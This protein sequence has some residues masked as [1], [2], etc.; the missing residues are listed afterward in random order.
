MRVLVYVSEAALQNWRLAERDG[1]LDH[2]HLHTTFATQLHLV[3]KPGDHEKAAAARRQEVGHSAGIERGDVEAA[4]PILD[5]YFELV[6]AEAQAD[7]NLL[8]RTAV[9]N[10]VSAS[11]LNGRHNV[12]DRL[13]IATVESQIVTNAVAR[14][15][16]TGSPRSEREAQT[17]RGPT[18]RLRQGRPSRSPPQ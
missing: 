10:D 18:A 17:C 7:L 5:Q 9:T 2:A 1:A 14:T 12:V 16:Q 11:L 3:A 8:L 4:A 15:E 6:S 13:L